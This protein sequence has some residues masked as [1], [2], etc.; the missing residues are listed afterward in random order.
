[1]I[2]INPLE[3][4]QLVKMF[5]HNKQYGIDRVVVTHRSDRPRVV[6]ATLLDSRGEAIAENEISDLESW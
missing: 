3:L 2:D 6:T 4:F 1:M 5:L